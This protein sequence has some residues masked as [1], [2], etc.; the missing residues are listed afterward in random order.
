MQDAISLIVLALPPRTSV[1]TFEAIPAAADAVFEATFAAPSI[2]VVAAVAVF[3][4]AVEAPA[5]A[6][7]VADAA[8]GCIRTLGIVLGFSV[9]S[10]MPAATLAPHFG[11]NDAVLGISLRHCVQNMAFPFL[12]GASDPFLV[13]VA[14]YGRPHAFL[15]ATNSAFL[16]SGPLFEGDLSRK[17]P[18]CDKKIDLRTSMASNFEKSPGREK[19]LAIVL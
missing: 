5:I 9:A 8:A 18:L 12:V 11:Q 4:A 14:S 17:R 6:A 15:C 19:P 10:G 13:L 16:V 3:A 1:L 7:V 2:A